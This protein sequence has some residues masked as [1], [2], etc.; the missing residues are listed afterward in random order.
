MELNWIRLTKQRTVALT[1]SNLFQKA[2]RIIELSP[3]FISKEGRLSNWLPKEHHLKGY[4]RI[5]SVKVQLLNRNGWLS[6][7]HRPNRTVNSWIACG[8]FNIQNAKLPKREIVRAQQ[9]QFGQVQRNRS[10]DAL[11]Q[12]SQAQWKWQQTQ[13]HVCWRGWRQRHRILFNFWG[14]GSKEKA[15]HHFLQAQKTC[16]HLRLAWKQER[17]ENATSRSENVVL[18]GAASV[19]RQIEGKRTWHTD[20]SPH[21]HETRGRKGMQTGC[22][23][24]T[25]AVP[26][27][28]YDAARTIDGGA[29]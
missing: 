26:K 9:W 2:G 22:I 11:L 1:N 29:C 28:H 25:T 8:K 27:G 21:S 20:C 17:Q 5:S 24:D 3:K 14:W 16:T 18:L 7:H 12:A 13:S 23:R 15:P 19:A 4:C 10:H 6:N